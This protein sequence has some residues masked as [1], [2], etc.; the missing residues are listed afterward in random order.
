VIKTLT[1]IQC[2]AVFL[3]GYTSIALASDNALRDSLLICA[4]IENNAERLDCVDK[5]IR[6]ITS[7]PVVESIEQHKSI[8]EP[9]FENLSTNDSGENELAQNHLRPPQESTAQTS[10]SYELIAV[11]K[12]NKNR[13]NFEFDNGE[14]WRQTESRYLRELEN[15][16]VSV[17]ISEGV[18]GSHDLRADDFGKA[19]KVKRLN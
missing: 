4:K 1:A 9:I 8:E 13:W 6:S 2:M 15:L 16:P 19:V 11:Y 7:Q 3:T 12:D 10:V 17:E 18:F 5:L 14:V